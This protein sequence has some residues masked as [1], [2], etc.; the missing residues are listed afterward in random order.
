[1]VKVFLCVVE[2]WPLRVRCN[3]KCRQ[4]LALLGVK[5]VDSI[6][7]VLKL[8][9]YFVIIYTT[10]LIE[11]RDNFIYFCFPFLIHGS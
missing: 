3:I 5:K 9:S 6:S 1:M 10:N 4:S 7:L 8:K 2:L 11:T